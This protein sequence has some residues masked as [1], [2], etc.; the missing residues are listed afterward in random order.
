M[1]NIAATK[2][3]LLAKHAKEA[4]EEREKKLDLTPILDYL[5]GELEYVNRAVPDNIITVREMKESIKY[6]EQKQTIENLIERVNNH[7]NPKHPSGPM[8]IHI[9]TVYLFPDLF[10]YGLRYDPTNDCRVSPMYD[11]I[12]K[13]LCNWSGHTYYGD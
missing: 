4:F 10:D 1:T 7:Q 12:G 11:A 2:A 3:R 9:L 5:K 8:N 6:H 13:V